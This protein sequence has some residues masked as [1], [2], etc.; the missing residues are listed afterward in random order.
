MKREFLENL[1]LGNGVKLPKEA[2][3]AIMAENG[4]DIE[5]HKTDAEAQKKAAEQVQAQLAEANKT[6][7]GFKALNVD[8][9]K[10]TAD[11]WKAKYETLKSDAEKELAALK[12]NTAVEQAL[13]AA[14]AKNPKSVKALLDLEK[15]KLD[16]DK[17]LG[18]D[19][20]LGAL[21]MSDGYLF[22]DVKT[23]DSGNPHGDGG[24]GDGK[25]LG[26]EIKSE[27]Y[28]ETAT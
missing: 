2:I 1:D 4:K 17:V 11:E 7:E 16:G 13:L 14:K 23:V 9:I 19:D 26:D 6:I 24:T 20:Q 25:T 15:I 22:G 18:L 10:K 21:K 5:K 8:E 27:L 12:L 28:G 3:D